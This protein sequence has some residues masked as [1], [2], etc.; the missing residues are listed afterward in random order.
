MF[1]LPLNGDDP[2]KTVVRLRMRLRNQSARII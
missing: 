2:N 1:A